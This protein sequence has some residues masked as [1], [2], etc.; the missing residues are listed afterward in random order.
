MSVE[1]DD[2]GLRILLN[3]WK[4]FSKAKKAVWCIDHNG[5]LDG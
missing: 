4:S 2:K 1:A 3:P 5:S